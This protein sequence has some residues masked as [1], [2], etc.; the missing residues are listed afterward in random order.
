MQLAAIL[1]RFSLDKPIENLV[2]IE[3]VK[4]VEFVFAQ[5]FPE[6]AVDGQISVQTLFSPK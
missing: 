4:L 2:L 3:V 6:R 1:S 5:I